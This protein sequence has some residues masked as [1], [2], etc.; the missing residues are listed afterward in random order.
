MPPV[1]LERQNFKE[2]PCK[3]INLNKAW[4]FTVGFTE[5]LK[6]T[7]RVLKFENHPFQKVILAFIYGFFDFEPEFDRVASGKLHI[8]PVSGIWFEKGEQ[9]KT[10]LVATA[11]SGGW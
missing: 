8:S 6:R 3:K 4:G 1:I 9:S 7:R 10:S 2:T 11:R 5:H